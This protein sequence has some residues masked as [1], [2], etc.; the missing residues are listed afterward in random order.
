ME[1]AQEKRTINQRNQRDVHIKHM[2][3]EKISSLPAQEKE[4]EPAKMGKKGNMNPL[5]EPKMGKT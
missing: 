3:G 5:L 1:L 2:P 4:S